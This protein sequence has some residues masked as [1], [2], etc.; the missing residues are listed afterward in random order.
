MNDFLVYLEAC[1]QTEVWKGE[2]VRGL[3]HRI[4]LQA[5][6]WVRG[7]QKQASSLIRQVSSSSAAHQTSSSSASAVDTHPVD[8]ARQLLSHALNLHSKDTPEDTR[9]ANTLTN[10]AHDILAKHSSSGR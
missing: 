7:P 2:H 10:M 5:T 1:T 4:L 3:A 9:H 8:M 6:A